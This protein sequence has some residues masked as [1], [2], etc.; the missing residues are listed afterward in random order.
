MIVAGIC[1]KE[2]Q[3]YGEVVNGGDGD[4]PVLG[5]AERCRILGT[6]NNAILLTPP[7]ELFAI[8]AQ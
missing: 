8:F 6:K 2:Q 4:C 3:R 1:R 5:C 7:N